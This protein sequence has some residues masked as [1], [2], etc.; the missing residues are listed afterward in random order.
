MDN[1]DPRSGVNY[2]VSVL[3]KVTRAVQLAPFAYLVF[4][5][6]FL[7]C[8]FYIPE[9]V[10]GILDKIFYVSP[11]LMGIMLCASKL[12]KLCH[13]HR[14]ACVIP[15]ITQLGDF[16]DSM[17]FQFTQSEVILF[18]ATVGILS[19]AFLLKANIHFKNGRQ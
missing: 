8:E 19:L 14:I 6:S 9:V 12:L 16:V 15:G 3:R 4:F 18:N 10:V 5:G 2:L 11:A 13:W 17:L 7:I 1:Q